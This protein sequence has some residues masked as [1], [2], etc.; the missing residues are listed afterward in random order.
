MGAC[1][2]RQ[3]SSN[4]AAEG[5]PATLIGAHRPDSAAAAMHGSAGSCQL[6]Q[7]VVLLIFSHLVRLCPRWLAHSTR[8]ATSSSARLQEPAELVARAALVNKAWCE[9]A[10]SSAAWDRRFLSSQ[11]PLPPKVAHLLLR[12]CTAGHP[13][14]LLWAQ[15]RP[16]NLLQGLGSISSLSPMRNTGARRAAVSGLLAQRFCAEPCPCRSVWV[17]CVAARRQRL[18]R[19]APPPLHA[20]APTALLLSVASELR[21]EPLATVHTGKVADRHHCRA[22]EATPCGLPGLQPHQQPLPRYGQAN[23]D[24]CVCL[25]SSFYWCE[26]MQVSCSGVPAACR[27]QPNS[28]PWHPWSLLHP[29]RRVLAL[30]RGIRAD[31]AQ[32]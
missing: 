22:R 15:L 31:T 19:L 7:D 20:C 18:V 6:P 2:L 23:P 29:G 1:L 13:W 17:G 11:Q 16:S 30:T 24:P 21:P 9:V 25:A 10:T 8:A 14:P 12:H 32:G 27:Q 5:L 28:V 3:K 26:V 4:L